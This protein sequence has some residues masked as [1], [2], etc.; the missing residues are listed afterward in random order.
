MLAD[1]ALAEAYADQKI[2]DFYDDAKAYD[3]GVTTTA[4][5]KLTGRPCPEGEGG[6]S[7]NM[8]VGVDENNKCKIYNEDEYREANRCTHPIIVHSVYEHE[9]VH[10]DQC[11]NERELFLNPTPQ[12]LGRHEQAAYL[13]GAT[14]L[15]SWMEMCCEEHD[16]APLKQRLKRLKGLK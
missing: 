7:L 11:N 10:L 16:I 8:W 1:L 15:L 5:V 14:I 6:P 9:K 13:K 12:S 2:R 4:C 3:R